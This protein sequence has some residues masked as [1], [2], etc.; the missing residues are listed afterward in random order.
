MRISIGGKIFNVFNVALMMLLCVVFLFPYL[1]QL[2]ISLNDGRDTAFGGIT[3][4][5]RAFTLQNYKTVFSNDSFNTALMISVLRVI[6]GTITGVVLTTA[7]AYALTKRDLPARTFFITLLLIPTFIDGGLIPTFILYR[8]LDLIN[9]FW[10]YIIPGLFSFYNM[11]IIRTYLNTIPASLEESAVLDGANS[12]QILTRIYLP[13]A[14]PVIATVSLWLA[15]AH[16]NDW[17]TSLMFVQSKDLHTLQFV[18]YRVLKESELIMQMAVEQSMQGGT[19]DQ[20]APS[21]TPE[22]VKAATLIVSTLPILIVY[23]FLQKYFVKGVMLGA[24]KE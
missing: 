17:V 15:V 13:L 16:W 14:K 4:Y 19:I 1:N 20:N 9:H 11:I 6:I 2:A 22:A 24:I 5:P 7:T 18:L 12:L 23:P 3:V 21:V 10:V 8:Y